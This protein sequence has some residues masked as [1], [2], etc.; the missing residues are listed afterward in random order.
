VW[1]CLAG[2]L[3]E[4]VAPKAIPKRRCRLVVA[5]F[6]QGVGPIALGGLVCSSIIFLL[7]GIFVSST[8]QQTFVL[9]QVSLSLVDALTTM[10]RS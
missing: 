2:A 4:I 6:G 3:M 9:L 5:T 10:S 8:R 7:L 1:W